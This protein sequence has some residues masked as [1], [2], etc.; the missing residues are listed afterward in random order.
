VVRFGPEKYWKTLSKSP[1][2]P[3]IFATDSKIGLFELAFVSDNTSNWTGTI[4]RFRECAMDGEA[5]QLII[6][7]AKQLRGMVRRMFLA[8][9]CETLCGGSSRQAESRFGWGRETV[10]KGL[11]ERALTAEERAARPSSGNRGR[12]PWEV[13]HP[14]LA[15]DIQLIVEPHTHTDPELKTDR[16]YTNMSAAEVRSALLEKGYSEEELPSERT[17][18]DI[19]NRMNYRLKR[20]QKGKPL[21]KTEHTDAIFDN[22]KSVRL[23]AAED[24]ETLEISV[25]T[26][27]KV[28]LGE[29]SQGGK[30]ENRQRRKRHQGVGS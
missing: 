23:S 19:L 5:D 14:Q 24:P 28:K 1:S 21:K 26:K 18:R 13:Q 7:A 15:I 4:H 3:S 9:V 2:I 11:T 30:N 25:D 27:A 29:Y 12:K 22:V 10:E 17:L 6:S 16:L 20:I 8:E